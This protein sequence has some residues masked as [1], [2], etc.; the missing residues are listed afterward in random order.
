MCIRDRYRTHPHVDKQVWGAERRIALRDPKRPF[1]LNQQVGVLRWRAITKDESQKPLGITVW[2][3]P[4]GDGGCEV[5]VE[6]ELE[7][8]TLELD[9]VSIVIPVPEGVA[10]EVTDPEDGSY[11][12]DAQANRVVWRLPSISALNPSAS[13]ELVV[14]YGADNVDVFFPV[15]VEFTAS[16]VLSGVHITDVRATDTAEPVAFAALAQL[17]TDNYL[18]H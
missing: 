3:S 14:P 17:G 16:R 11:A 5:N 7:H 8:T 13:L 9:A 15:S 6:Y 12:Y 2:L 10:P 4:T 18:V 1:P